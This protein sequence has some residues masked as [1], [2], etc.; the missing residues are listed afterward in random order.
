MFKTAKDHDP[1]CI[2]AIVNI[3]AIEYEQ[4]AHYEDAALLFL[5]ALEINPIDEEALGNL[6]LALKHTSYVDYAKLAFEEA[7]NVNPGNTHI[8]A[9][10]MFFLLEQRD[11]SQFNKVLPHAR[12]VMDNNEELAPIV[13][14][15]TEF[16]EAIEG[17]DGKSIPSDDQG[18]AMGA[19]KGTN[20]SKKLQ[21]QLR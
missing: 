4:F 7:V 20:T 2:E 3:G 1:K 16:K 17:T 19:P 10:Y 5:D 9:N 14:I 12:R 8:L 21:S 11:F 15:Y 13:K 18:L 6:A